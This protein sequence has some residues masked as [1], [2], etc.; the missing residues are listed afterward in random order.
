[1]GLRH[2][3]TARLTGVQFDLGDGGA[4][5]GLEDIQP[6]GACCDRSKGFREIFAEPSARENRHPVLALQRLKFKFLHPAGI[7]FV[8]MH[9]RESGRRGE[10]GG[11]PGLVRSGISRPAG[12]WVVIK[13]HRWSVFGHALKDV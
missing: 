7:G 8:D 6:H 1:M 9:S 4:I 10:L 11:D 13:R 5:G 2:K 12:V 3:R